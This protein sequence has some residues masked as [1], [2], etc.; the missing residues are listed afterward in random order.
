MIT[1]NQAKEFYR[2][3]CGTA[4]GDSNKTCQ[5]TMSEEHIADLMGISNE[6]VES[7]CKAMITHGITERQG[8]C[9]VV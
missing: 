2:D 5:G 3:L 4:Y 9:I 1:K 6:R 7:F 8:G